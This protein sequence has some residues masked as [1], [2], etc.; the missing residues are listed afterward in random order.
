MLYESGPQAEHF[1]HS[2][3]NAAGCCKRVAGCNRSGTL[4]SSSGEL[5]DNLTES[6]AEVLERRRYRRRAV[7]LLC[8][9]PRPILPDALLRAQVPANGCC[10]VD[11]K[12]SDAP[13]P[14]LNARY[15]AVSSGVVLQRRAGSCSSDPLIIVEGLGGEARTLQTNSPRRSAAIEDCLEGADR[16]QTE[17]AVSTCCANSWTRTAVH[18]VKSRRVA[19]DSI[20]RGQRSSHR[21]PDRSRQRSTIMNTSS[22]MPGADLD[23]DATGRGAA[24]AGR[25]HREQ[26]C[27]SSTPGSASGALA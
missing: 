12:R 23:R 20:V 18:R 5:S 26:P 3:R 1:Q 13:S 4:L 24:R 16:S 19:T 17:S 10:A 11:G 9:M 2:G 22:I 8:G 14:E 21:V 7:S 15:A 6:A 27:S 25:G